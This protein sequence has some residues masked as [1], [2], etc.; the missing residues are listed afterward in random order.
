MAMARIGIERDI[1]DKAEI[2]HFAFDRAASPAN[3]IPRI[4]RLARLFIAQAMVGEREK[5]KRRNPEL[6]RIYCRAHGKVDGK[7]LDAGHGGNRLPCVFPF[8]KKNWPDEI[9]GGERVFA[10]EPARPAGL[11]VAPQALGKIEFWRGPG[12]RSLLWGGL[13]FWA[14]RQRPDHDRLQTDGR[15]P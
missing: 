5:R 9:G 2:W 1:G 11:A 3:E 4:E 8:A 12:G 15:R 7:P 10:H 14:L 13:A 6:N